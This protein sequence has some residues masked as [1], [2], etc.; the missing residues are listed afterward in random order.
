[1]GS[2]PV[3]IFCLMMFSVLGAALLGN[4]IFKKKAPFKTILCLLA[5]TFIWCI[6]ITDFFISHFD[7]VADVD[8]A[9]LEARSEQL[10]NITL[11]V[12]VAVGILFYF[13]TYWRIRKIQIS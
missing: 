10:K 5:L 13:L 1:M 6:F 12:Y 8:S 4:V 2:I 11:I 7:L 9:V 3:V